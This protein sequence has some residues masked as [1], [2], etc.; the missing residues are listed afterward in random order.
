MT[1][2]KRPSL[3]WKAIDYWLDNAKEI[4][5]G[6]WAICVHIQNAYLAGAK[7]QRQKTKKMKYA[8]KHGKK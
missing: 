6:K 1:A 2:D 4:E 3:Y 8:K 5:S 7:A